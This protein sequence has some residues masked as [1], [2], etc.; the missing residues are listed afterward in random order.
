MVP[1]TICLT[2]LGGKTLM[3]YGSSIQLPPDG[4][5]QD[6][7]EPLSKQREFHRMPPCDE[8]PRDPLK[9]G[10]WQTER[11]DQGTSNA[12]RGISHQFETK[13]GICARSV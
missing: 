4:F 10:S 13:V 1:K 7:N 6:C 2:G 5:K 3:F 8:W 11:N 9:P 12:L